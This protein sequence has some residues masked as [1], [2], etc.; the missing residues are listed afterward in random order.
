MAVIHF[1][2]NFWLTSARRFDCCVSATQNF[3]GISFMI[4]SGHGP[5]QPEKFRCL[6]GLGVV[7]LS[8]SHECRNHVTRA[9]ADVPDYLP[10]TWADSRQKRAIGPRLDL[11]A[12]ETVQCQLGALK[13]NN[14]PHQDHG[15]E[16]MYRFA[17]FDPF[18][19]SK[20]FGTAFDLGQFERFRRIFHHSTYRVLLSHKASKILSS[21][22][23]NENCF[24]QRVWIKGSRPDEEEIF[25]FTMVQRVGGYWDGYWL[26]ESLRHDGEGVPRGIPY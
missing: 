14:E 26:T 1:Q 15:V 16:V 25:E 13:Y 18:E 3:P 22:Y 4:K 19:R 5:F 24:K 20:Y 6:S 8:F 23:V 7:P 2:L 11:T 12:E 9:S 21:L 17:G 10:A